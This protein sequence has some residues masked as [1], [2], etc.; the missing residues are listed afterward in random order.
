MTRTPEELRYTEE[1]EWVRR[2][3]PN[4]VRIGITDYAQSQLGDVVFA[5]NRSRT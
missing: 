2:V 1:H 4:R 5:R 3:A